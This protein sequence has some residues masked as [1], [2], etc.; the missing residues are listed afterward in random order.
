MGMTSDTR[1]RIMVVSTVLLVG[2]VL[3]GAILSQVF[4]L[5]FVQTVIIAEAV[6]TLVAIALGGVFAYYK[7][8]L[9]RDFQ[10][11]LT[12]TQKISHRR[13]GDRHVHVSVVARLTNSSKV[14]VEIRN[15]LFRMQ[16]IAPVSDANIRQM[17][18]E[19][20]SKPNEEKY[21][22]FPTLVE[23]QRTWEKD[24]FVIEP[25]ETES[26][27]YEFI[28]ENAFD[29]VKLTA[30]FTDQISIS[31]QHAERGWLAVSVYDVNC[32][33]GETQ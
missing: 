17:Y 12:I 10:P 31:E 26:E 21:F 33:V 13:I 2:L 4:G 32:V 3:V 25:G 18:S 27:N 6:V 29:T 30:F 20:E 19:F 14:V 11:H 9:F 22:P 5:G 24:E 8:D 28:V 7:L 1:K 16:E 15:A 23:F